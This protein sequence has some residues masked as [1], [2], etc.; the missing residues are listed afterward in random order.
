MCSL[1]FCLYACINQFGSTHSNLIEINQYLHYIQFCL[2]ICIQLNWKSTG[3]ITLDFSF[4]VILLNVYFLET[5]KQSVDG[6]D[7]PSRL[8]NAVF[9]FGGGELKCLGCFLSFFRWIFKLLWWFLF[10][11]IHFLSIHSLLS[12]Y[13]LLFC[14]SERLN[15]HLVTDT[16]MYAFST[17]RD[18][19]AHCVTHPMYPHV[20]IFMALFIKTH[21]CSC[22]TFVMKVIHIGHI[23]C[24]CD[25]CLRA[26]SM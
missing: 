23:H 7:V 10:F 9:M 1:G 17:H 3:C 12:L 16:L 14:H 22:D 2:N 20:D 6:S 13:S 4:S 24:I 26:N 19:C 15:V 11:M 18:M 5:E 21:M 8:E 25:T